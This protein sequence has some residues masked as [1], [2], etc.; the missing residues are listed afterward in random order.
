MNVDFL[1]L[2]S[3][4]VKRLCKKERIPLST[5][6]RDNIY[7]VINKEK[8][9]EVANRFLN[10]LCNLGFGEITDEKP[11]CFKRYHPDDMMCPDKENLKSTW[12]KL[13]IDV[14]YENMSENISNDD[15]Q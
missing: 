1:I 2:H 11:K 13:K 15:K 3:H 14:K 8:S 7:P 9:S 6:T 12:K 10:G 5:I 4:I